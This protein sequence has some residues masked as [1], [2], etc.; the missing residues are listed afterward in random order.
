MNIDEGLFVTVHGAEQWV[1]MRGRDSTN[2]VLLLISG[3]GAAL[4]GMA[5]LFAA[6]EREFTFVQWDQPA[7]GATH[8][9]SGD[10]A[11]G[12]L[13]IDRI[14]RDG[15]AVTEF[16]CR[17]L[18][19]ARIVLVGMSGGSIVGLHMV[20]RRPDLFC[21]YVG[22][23]QIVDWAR[24]DA[25]SYVMVLEQARAA[26]DQ[27]AIEALTQ[28]GPP[29]YVD[30]ATDAIKSKYASAM[31]SDEH[32]AFGAVDPAVMAAVQSPPADA[33]YIARGVTARDARTQAMA[34]YTAL[35]DEIV[36]FDARRLGL[37]FDVP[38]FFFQGD[39][40]AYTVTSEVQ[41]YESEIR[42]PKKML[43]LIEGGGHSCLMFMRDEFLA[44]LIRFVRPLATQMSH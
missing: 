42:A 10:V 22:T 30:V 19:T 37:D 1:T 11:A 39:H 25:A 40:D 4:S 17:R 23:G 2:P 24:Q 14:V 5:P 9:R 31:T 27:T 36:A 20:K 21:A 33:R 43:V 29:P 8:A 26:H 18:E 38:M 32:A 6:W 12:E 41:A 13:S 35:R 34:A 7:A 16:V 44:L 28:I 15:I 3:A